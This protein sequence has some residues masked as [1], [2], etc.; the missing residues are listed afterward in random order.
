MELSDVIA[1][2][3]AGFT[4]EQIGQLMKTNTN[5]PEPVPAPAPAPA[6]AGPAA[7]LRPSCRL[8]GQQLGARRPAAGSGELLR[9]GDRT[10]GTVLPSPSCP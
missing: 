4:A 1:L 2:A 5:P 10:A 8:A 7:G 6:P 9:G 3:K